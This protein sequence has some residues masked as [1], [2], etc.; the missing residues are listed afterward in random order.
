MTEVPYAELHAHSAFSFLDGA[1]QPEE[2]VAEAVRLGLSALAITDHDGLYGVV[3]FA[4]AA[5]DAGLDTVW[6]GDRRGT[7]TS[8]PRSPTRTW[9]PATRALRATPS[10]SS[11]SSPRGSGWC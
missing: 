1:S 10:T 7:A 2:M 11:V 4:E 3:R 8:P 5:R 9:R 6:P